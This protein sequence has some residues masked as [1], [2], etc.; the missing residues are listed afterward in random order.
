M[1]D[2]RSAGLVLFRNGKPGRLYLL[3]HYQEG[4]WDMPK[5]HIEKGEDEVAAARRE[6]LEETGI[7]EI[8][9][10]PGFRERI[11]YTYMR[12][13]RAS[14]KEVVYLLGSTSEEKVRLSHEHQGHDWLG[15]GDA[16][17]RLTYENAKEV[18]GKAELFLK[19]SGPG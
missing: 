5:G 15:F 8:R 9:L 14:E 1:P 4:H 6:C 16:L 13:G 11:E 7:S 12:K 3:L 17:S 18:L 10:V 2:E 19:K